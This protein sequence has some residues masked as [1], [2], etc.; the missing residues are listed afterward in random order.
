MLI[1]V[2]T[3]IRELALA[4]R[5]RRALQ[6][7][8][9]P[10]DT[11]E[12]A[13]AR[14]RF[15]S[16]VLSELDDDVELIERLR[17]EPEDL[18]IAVATSGTDPDLIRQLVDQLEALPER[19]GLI[20]LHLDDDPRTHAALLG[21]GSVAVLWTGLSSEGLA[22]ALASVFERRRD[23]SIARAQATRPGSP[24][25]EP[26]VAASLVM[27]ELLETVRRVAVAD[28]PVLL[29]GETGVGKERIAQLLHAWSPRSR[30]PFVAL[31]CAAIPGELFESELFGHERG[32]FTGA[33]RSR[34]GQFELA[35]RGTLFLDEIAEIPPAQQAKLLRAL[36]DKRIRPIG[37]DRELPVDVRVVAA[38]NQD[39]RG[40]MEAGRF[41]R[42][43]FYR[44]G[45]VELTIPPLR[46]RPE[47][48]R[49]LARRYA[50]QFATRL[51]RPIPIPN[52]EALARLT[53]H[54]W[55]GNV[56]ELI[57]VVERAVLL[58]T[59]VTITAADL[60]APLGVQSDAIA[61]QVTRTAARPAL[62]EVGAAV[63]LPPAWLEQPWKQ[64]REQLLLA[65]ERAYL[66]GLLRACGGRIGD[67]ARRAGIA[68]RSLFEKMKRHG[69]RKED[70]RS[71]RDPDTSGS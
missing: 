25:P 46:T 23:E 6:V 27:R 47:D 51:G 66:I 68:E 40:A 16:V 28:S 14:R 33:V 38:T 9:A 18:L 34:R 17:R 67:C 21:A 52:E 5:V 60:P 45:V 37:A 32:A 4:E 11:L 2:G 44:L 54:D 19:T 64:V 58:C 29:L 63:E 20:L 31:N 1:R 13:I 41:R 7:E 70:F 26:L 30:G 22:E 42:D 69:L 8:P 57:N 12:E 59:G 15:D 48:I 24:E 10:G 62:G 65:G 56:R 36:Q 61:A 3:L 50:K 49:E 39:L 53:A 35:H 71:T 55:P 43:L